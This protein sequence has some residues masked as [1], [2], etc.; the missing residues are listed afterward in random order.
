[1]DTTSGALTPV[2]GSP[3]AGP[4]GVRGRMFLSGDQSTLISVGEGGSSVKYSINASDGSLTRAQT[5]PF[6]DSA[7]R[8]FIVVAIDS[9]AQ[10]M[11]AIKDFG[12]ANAT[13]TG[14]RISDSSPI[15]GLGMMVQRVVVHPGQQILYLDGEA[16]DIDSNTGSLSASTVSALPAST[17]ELTAD[18]L[19]LVHQENSQSTAAHVYH[20]AS[21][22]SSFSEASGS[23]INTPGTETFG[24]YLE[25]SGKYLYLWNL[26]QQWYGYR[27]DTLQQVRPDP[28]ADFAIVDNTGKFA[29]QT[30][31][32]GTLRV[33]QYDSSTGIYGS[34]VSTSAVPAITNVR[35]IVGGH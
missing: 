20:R 19:T 12:T 14:I 22:T 25:T 27:L 29:V 2:P 35:F 13:L 6:N 18:G 26:D 16:F 7:S 31:G 21:L 17:G 3:I 8:D 23:P 15:S 24:W 32:N 9:S 28:F 1:M 30:D 10:F 5:I 34:T 33:Q 4:T 11:Y